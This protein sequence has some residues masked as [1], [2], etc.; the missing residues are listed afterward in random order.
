MSEP[1]KHPPALE[2]ILLISAFIAGTVDVIGFARLCGIFASAMTG[3]LAFLGLYLARGQALAAGGSMVALCGF[4]AGAAAGT[5]AVRRRS[6][7][8][9][10]SRLLSGEVVLFAAVAAIWFGVTAHKIGMLGTDTMVALLSVAMGAQSIVGK[11][12]NLSGIPTVVFTSTLSNIVVGITDAFAGEKAFTVG[13]DTR[14][15]LT[16][17]FLYLFGAFCAGLLVYLDTRLIILLPLLAA[18]AALAVHAASP[19]PPAA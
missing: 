17:F 8:V 16:S 7:H 1:G 11:Q 4:I 19:P 9:A 14:R 18:A 6:R 3:N 10:L 2:Y 12:I 13:V 15:Q 5:I